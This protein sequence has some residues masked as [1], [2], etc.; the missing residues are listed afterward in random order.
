M[1]WFRESIFT[2]LS[3]LTL[4]GS[5]FMSFAALENSPE[6]MQEFTVLSQLG[7]CAL[8]VAEPASKAMENM[9]EAIYFITL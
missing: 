2:A 6:S 7:A 3:R 9:Q 1:I 5:F 8:A 4:V